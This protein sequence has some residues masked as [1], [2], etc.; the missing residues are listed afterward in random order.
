MRV[1]NRSVTKVLLLAA[2]AAACLP[3]RAAG[4][5][6]F[7][8][9]PTPNNNSG[10]G[11]GNN[12]LFAVS[13]S[14]PSDIWAVGESVIHFDGTTW[15]AFP[16]PG[17]DGIP[18][19]QMNGVADISP[20]DAWAAGNLSAPLLLGGGPTNQPVIEHWDGTQWSVFPS[21]PFNKPGESAQL[22]A[23]TAISANDIWVVGGAAFDG[24]GG[25]LFEHWDGTAWTPSIVF[26]GGGIAAGAASSD[27]TDDVW[28]VGSSGLSSAQASTFVAH[29]NG[30]VWR[31]VPSPN[32]GNSSAFNGVVALAPNDV[33]AVGSSTAALHDP[34][35][36]LIEHYDGTEWSVVPSPNVGPNSMNQSNRLF[37]I[38]AVSPTDIW[39][40]G[41]YFAA[42]GSGN[43][44]TLLLHWNGTV[45]SI[46]SSPNPTNQSF[47]TD[48]LF[49]GVVPSPGNVW[50][51]GTEDALDT[52][53]IH[54]TNGGE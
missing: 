45:W 20:T 30:T 5:S 13:A 8:V 37:G 1:S 7:Q 40:F 6:I 10:N 36:T 47:L 52:L 16:A 42:D 23:I 39:A 12:G 32:V 31:S 27:A 54:T 51:V 11:L 50:I 3:A 33:W 38:T 49:A 26:L 24:S 46:A 43:Q 22:S 21:P 29:F 2:M 15:T 17:I 4:L 44:M 53:A 48:V 34:T 35:L 14:S 9:V 41:S 28:A 25:N 19:S 18:P